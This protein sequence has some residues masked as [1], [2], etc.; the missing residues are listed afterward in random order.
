MNE[1]GKKGPVGNADFEAAC[2]EELKRQERNESKLIQDMENYKEWYH[3]ALDEKVELNAKI[4]MLEEV[5]KA[6]AAYIASIKK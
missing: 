3:Q 1:V 2:K 4:K 6:Q 5:V